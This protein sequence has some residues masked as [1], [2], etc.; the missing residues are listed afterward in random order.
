MVTYYRVTHMIW[1]LEDLAG[2]EFGTALIKSCEIIEHLCTVVFFF[3]V[4][5]DSSTL[6]GGLST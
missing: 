1:K 6:G 3:L 4:E 2:F 5:H